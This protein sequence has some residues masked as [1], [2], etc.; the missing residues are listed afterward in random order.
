MTPATKNN[1]F[2]LTI[3]AIGGAMVPIFV[4]A[5]YARQK[6]HG[7]GFSTWWPYVAGIIV[8]EIFILLAYFKLFA[9]GRVG[10][11]YGASKVGSV[12]LVMI[13]AVLFFHEPFTYKT[14]AGV[15]FAAAAIYLLL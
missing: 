12:I 2:W 14:L 10:A 13:V 15:I 3:A 11:L 7:G 1:V 5:G 8:G 4:K 9:Q 6:S